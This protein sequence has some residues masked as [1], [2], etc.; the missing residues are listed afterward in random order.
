MLQV[1]K[2]T[3]ES[4]EAGPV[5]CWCLHGA[6]GAAADWRDFTRT[7]ASHRIGSRAVDLWRFLDCQPMTLAATARALHAEAAAAPQGGG[8]I[9]LGYSLGGRIALHALLENDPPWQAAVIVSAHPGL[10][11][12]ADR[13]AR[14]AAD[15]VWATK[16]L[17]GNWADFL[18][19]W[20]AQPVLAGQPIRD[21]AAGTRLAQRRREIARSFID[22]SLGAQDPLW[23]RLAT[24]RIPVL[25][26]AGE[27]D[28]K[29]VELARRATAMIPRAR[30]A[31]APDCGH[32][33]PWQAGDWL[34]AEVARFVATGA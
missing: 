16:A 31:I 34:A 29:F 32:R 5:H 18:H 12:P 9:L 26:V 6:V 4:R 11:D 15:A 17:T 1:F 20:Q 30:L 25:W 28:H 22:W 13:E 2:H 21:P 33:V 27:Q 14:R 8:R 10:D 7:L 24:I 3:D 19:D 23:P